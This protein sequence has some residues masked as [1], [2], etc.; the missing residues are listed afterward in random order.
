M[1]TFIA[2]LHIECQVPVSLH[3]A[4]ADERLPVGRSDEGLRNSDFSIYNK[5]VKKLKMIQYVM[6]FDVISLACNK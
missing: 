4:E 3:K 1:H 2:Y 5:V 6:S